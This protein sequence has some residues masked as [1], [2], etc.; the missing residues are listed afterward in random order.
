MYVDC[1]IV[2]GDRDLIGLT[3]LHEAAILYARSFTLPRGQFYS[4]SIRSRGWITLFVFLGGDGALQ[5]TGEGLSGTGAGTGT[6]LGTG[7]T[8]FK[9]GNNTR[10]AAVE[11]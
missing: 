8:P 6:A 3:Y 4:P 10:V 7:I 5:K 2:G 11:A 9:S 1:S